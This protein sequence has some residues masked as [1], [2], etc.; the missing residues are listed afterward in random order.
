MSECRLND[1]QVALWHGHI[2]GLADDGT[3]GMKLG[4]HLRQLV[5]VLQIVERSVSAIIF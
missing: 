3:G 1:V 4:G 5:E 2:H